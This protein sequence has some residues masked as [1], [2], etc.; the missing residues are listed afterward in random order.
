MKNRYIIPAVLFYLAFLLACKQKAAFSSPAGYDFGNPEKFVMPESLL[1]ISGICFKPTTSDTI[2]AVQD[3]EGKLFRQR[4]GVKAQQN[5][6]FAAGGD[7][8]DVTYLKGWF[9]VL[10]SN[11]HMYGFKEEPFDK[12]GANDTRVFKQLVP[13]GEYE[14]LFAD[15]SSGLLYVLCKNC[16]TGERGSAPGYV[17]GSDSAGAALKLVSQFSVTAGV[18]LAKKKKKKQAAF[19]PSALARHPKT[20]EWFVLSSF[21][22]LL[23]IV[24]ENWKVQSRHELDGGVFNQP[25]GM[26]FDPEGNL[27][28]SNEGGEL[29]AGNVLKFTYR[30]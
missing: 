30:R 13:K 10:K 17:L 4:W 14:G 9:Y 20:G 8:E 23:L 5:M 6:H 11:G 25:E 7:Y 19:R 18:S 27:Y 3:E 28:I 12:N 26:A 1:E 29:D 15:Q 24:D 21:N 2:Y 16:K 22:K